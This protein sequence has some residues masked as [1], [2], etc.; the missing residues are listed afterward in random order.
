VAA[1][2]CIAELGHADAKVTLE[3]YAAPMRRE[4]RQALRELVYG[5]ELREVMALAA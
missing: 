2:V 3:V 1:P 4:D 5:T